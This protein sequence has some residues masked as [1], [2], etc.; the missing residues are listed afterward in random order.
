MRIAVEHHTTKANARQI[1][2]RKINNLLQSY[3]AQAD[4]A[5]HEWRGDTLYFKGKARGF[6]I[7]GTVDI[8][9]TDVILDGKLP[10]IAR[11]FEGKIRQTVEAEAERMFRT[12]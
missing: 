8:T 6:N 1:V 10:L 12:A 2:E 3:G 5:E 4:Q 7:E 11:A 9:D